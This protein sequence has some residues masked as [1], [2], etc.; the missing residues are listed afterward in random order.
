M[1]FGTAF[2]GFD[3]DTESVDVAL[4]LDRHSGPVTLQLKWGDGTIVSVVTPFEA[5]HAYPGD[6]VYTIR[7]VETD[8]G[9]T[10]KLNV[11]LFTDDTL[12]RAVSGGRL[13]DL[14]SGG[15]GDD[16]LL[17][18]D[19]NDWIS[20][21]SGNDFIRPGDGADTA[22]GGSGDDII[23]SPVQDVPAE[24][25]LD[26]FSGNQ[27]NDTLIGT[28]GTLSGGAGDD[29]LHSL[30]GTDRMYGGKGNDTLTSG[31]TAEYLRGG[32]GD[33]YL[34]GGIRKHGGEG[35]DTLEGGPHSL[36]LD[37]PKDGDRDVF[38]FR[39]P[40][41]V[42]DIITG[43]V[44]GEDVIRIDWVSAFDDPRFTTTGAVTD[45]GV[46]ISYDIKHGLLRVDLDGNGTA[47]SW[48]PVATLKGHSDLSFSD[49][50]FFGS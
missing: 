49:L 4:A 36:Y 46:W 35:A 19:G 6:G 2:T 18:G 50:R 3:R 20:A 26:V 23:F 39:E 11:N 13:D 9:E 47:H 30:R 42:A 15:S 17:G 22:H 37:T 29:V 33:D 27:G 40:D 1:A 32:G 24:G 5:T 38:L 43:F 7:V 8:T 31:F 28:G 16:S 12:G 21:G 44:P 48:I 45:N 41:D 34:S 14:I 25:L 10:T